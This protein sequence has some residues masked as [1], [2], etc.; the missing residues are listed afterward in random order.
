MSKK[1]KS[2][3]K[4]VN[5][6][7]DK[8]DFEKGYYLTVPS[9]LLDKKINNKRIYAGYLLTYMAIYDNAFL[10]H[11]SGVAKIRPT[12]IATMLGITRRTAEYHIQ[13]LISNKLILV[14]KRGKKRLLVPKYI[15]VENKQIID[16]NKYINAQLNTMNISYQV[17]DQKAI[18]T[19]QVLKSGLG[20]VYKLAHGFIVARSIG[21]SD[22]AW[23][24][25]DM[26]ELADYLEVSISTAY[27]Y[28]NV[29]LTKSGLLKRSSDNRFQF[30]PTDDYS[31]AV[32]KRELAERE[33]IPEETFI[34]V[35]PTTTLPNSK[36]ADAISKLFR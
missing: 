13:W 27:R 1:I 20:A 19:T 25:L 3:M 34:N 24:Y 15:D 12:T 36:V 35:T 26:Q 8:D 4:Q 29:L 28:I 23:K 21:A 11:N 7:L 22:G 31:I 2:I 17:F 5:N 9:Y 33:K 16:G 10:G 14:I 6:E 32:R 30:I 18:I